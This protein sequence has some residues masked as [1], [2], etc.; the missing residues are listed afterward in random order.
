MRHRIDKKFFNRDTKSR[1]SLLHGV[2]IALFEHGEILTTRAKGKES[3]RLIDSLISQAKVGDLK[4]RRNLHRVFGRTDVVNNLCDRVAP[5]FKD[6]QSGFC[7]LVLVGNRRGD[8]TAMYRLSLVEVLPASKKS[9]KAA[10]KVAAKAEA[11]QAK[12][13][14]KKAG[15]AEKVEKATVSADK[16]AQA[17]IAKD[18]NLDEKVSAKKISVENKGGR[19]TIFGGGRGK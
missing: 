19:R 15:K 17:A 11:A 2:A 10:A 8:N 9:E 13:S 12:K 14:T 6:R 18:K 1:R 5:V 16:K 3:M 7:R 4:A